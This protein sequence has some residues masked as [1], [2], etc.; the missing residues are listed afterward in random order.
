MNA[1][2]DLQATDLDLVE[3]FQNGRQEAFNT[4]VG[5]HKAK[6][7]Q[8]AWLATGNWEDAKDVSQEAFVKA[9]GALKSFKKQAKFST[10]LYTVVMNTA[11]DYWRRKKGLRWLDWGKQEDMDHF[12]ESLP[13][14]AVQPD[15][16]LD[17]KDAA[18]RI[19]ATIA[20]LPERQRMI[21]SLRFLEDLSLAEIAGILGISEGTV[22]AGLHFAVK[23][24]KEAFA[25]RGAFQGGAHG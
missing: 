9:Y 12:F 13:S 19:N 8:L 23:K 15:R 16:T 5:R 22:K 18:A 17:S 25:G 2:A 21:F 4:L 1:A 10:W 7:L 6:A 3:A 14:R 20:G 11:R 24:F